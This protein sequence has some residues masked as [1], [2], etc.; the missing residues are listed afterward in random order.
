[1]TRSDDLKRASRET[2]DRLSALGIALTG[3]ESADELLAIEESVERFEEAVEAHGGDLMVDEG[4][5]G[6][7]PQPDDPHFALPRRRK[8]ETVAAYLEGLARATDTVRRHRGKD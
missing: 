5:R 6:Q 2:A 3:H 8:G 1:M 7:K 4:P